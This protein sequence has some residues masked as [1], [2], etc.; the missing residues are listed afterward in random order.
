MYDPTKP[1]YHTHNQTRIPPNYEPTIPD[2]PYSY[3]PYDLQNIPLPPKP[4]HVQNKVAFALAVAL[5]VLLVVIIMLLA[6]SASFATGKLTST[7]GK[8]ADNKPTVMP[9]A[10]RETVTKDTASVLMKA[11]ISAGFNKDAADNYP[12]TDWTCCQYYPEGGAYAFYDYN[13]CPGD[14]P[15]GCWV[16]IAVFNSHIEAKAD[17]DT[18]NA[19]DNSQGAY[20]MGVDTVDNC[21]LT[22][23]PLVNP[24]D[25]KPIITEYE[26]VMSQVCVASN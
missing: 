18:L 22:Y 3:S 23:D 10:I 12:Y 14:G 4:P 26:R 9:T 20:N 13:W 5:V 1:G 8:G 17:A 15:G 2:N 7:T 16:H 25:D 21:L 19:T 24:G 6:V 11:I